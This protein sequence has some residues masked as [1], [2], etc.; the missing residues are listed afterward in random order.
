[1]P[2]R[3]DVYD[4][5]VHKM[6][7]V[8]TLYYK[9]KLSQQEIAERLHMSRPWISKLLSRAEENG[10]V[11]IDIVPPYTNNAI[12]ARELAEKYELR[13]AHV[14]STDGGK[15]LLAQAAAEYFVDQLRENDVIGVGWGTSVSHLIDQISPASYPHVQVVPL[16]G[17]FGNSISHFPNYSAM[18]LAESLG[19]TARVLHTP[20]LCASQEEYNTLTANE[21]TRSVLEL[22]ERSDILLVGIGA[23][24]DSISPQYGVFGEAEIEELRQANAIGDVALQYLDKHGQGVDVPTT[25]RLIRADIFKASANARISLG[26]AAGLHK[27]GTINAALRLRLVNTLFTDEQTALAL[28]GN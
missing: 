7:L 27:V 22:A 4:P 19:A 8:A 28:L 21:S 11:K 26:I 13:Y 10:I 25:R 14:S 12:L 1:M 24:A 15:D 16:A 17:S 23:F 9:E 5:I 3:Y 6:V 18:R 2:N 20:A